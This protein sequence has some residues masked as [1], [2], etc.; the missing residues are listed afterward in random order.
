MNLIMMTTPIERLDGIEHPENLRTA[1]I[2]RSL[3]SERLIWQLGL[4]VPMAQA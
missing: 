4:D 1:A 2:P 3:L